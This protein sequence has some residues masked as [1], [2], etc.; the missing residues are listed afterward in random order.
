MPADSE[1][2]IIAKVA[3]AAEGGVIDLETAAAAFGSSR[4][5]ASRRM[6]A[7]VSGGWLSRV[8]R[9][10]YS[11]RP[12]DAAP[13]TAL[14]EEDPWIIAERVFNPCYIGG[15]TAAG[16]WDLTEQLYRATMV[17]TE[18]RVR[19]ADVTIGSSVYHVARESHKRSNGLSHVWRNNS[20]L[21]VS[22]VERTIIDACTHPGWVGGG[23]QLI[24]IFR[25]AVDDARITAESV[26]S[27]VTEAPTGAALGRLAVLVDRYWPSAMD[28]TAYLAEHRGAGYVRFDPDVKDNGS[29]NTRWGVWLNVAFE[30][31]TT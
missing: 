7:L 3:S 31:D 29:L 16:Y 5:E 18:R 25:S 11:I 21:L 27:A 19:R 30:A 10:V 13:G 1:R 17:V 4:L 24:A 26:L 8:R 28:V 12:L 9:G 23:G 14:A 20:R 22:S 15:W 2:E 6:S